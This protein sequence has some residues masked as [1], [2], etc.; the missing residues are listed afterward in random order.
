[1][2]QQPQPSS[3]KILWLGVLALAFAPATPVHADDICPAAVDRAAVSSSR[4]TALAP[5]ERLCYATDLS[6]AGDWLLDAAAGNLAPAELRLEILGRSC[7]SGA[8]GTRSFRV[9]HRTAAA[10]LVAVREP[11][12]YLFCVT[13]RDPQRGIDSYRLT[14]AFSPGLS[15]GN[16]DEDEPDPDPMAPPGGDPRL[17]TSGS[18]VAWR[19]PCRHLS[20]GDRATVAGCATDLLLGRPVTGVLDDSRGNDVHVFRLAV[21]DWVTVAVETWGEVDTIGGLYGPQGHRLAADDDDGEGVNFRL[22]ETLGPGEY[23]VRV[24]GHEGA[25]GRYR[26]EIEAVDRR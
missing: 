15:K 19:G 4:E 1:M 3:P 25:S 10:A 2:S 5:G 24:E 11:G 12:R 9:R 17:L 7:E 18:S 13:P 14:T 21:D 23:F 6:T 16:P 20:G 8:T 22:V 26:L